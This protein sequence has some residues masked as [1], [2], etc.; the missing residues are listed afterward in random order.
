MELLG[1]E[2]TFIL[3]VAMTILMGLVYWFFM[4]LGR[5]LQETG[6]LGPLASDAIANAE[7]ARREKRL[8]ED[9]A[10]GDITAAHEPTS[11][12]FKKLYDIP[13]GAVAQN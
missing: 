7:I 11:D 10:R 3:L 5:R 9:L 12:E 4:N 2:Y 6:Y 1:R 13:L 8:R